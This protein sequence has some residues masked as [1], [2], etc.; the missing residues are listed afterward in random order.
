MRRIS[1]RGGQPRSSKRGRVSPLKTASAVSADQLAALSIAAREASAFAYCPYS[2]FRVGA[3]VLTSD[4]EIVG[5]CNVENA[6][7]GLSIC[8]ERNAIFQAVARGYPQI[9]ALVLYTPTAKPVTPCGACRQVLAEFG[10]EAAGVCICDGGESIT[11]TLQEL[12]AMPLGAVEVS[13]QD[14][15]PCPRA[16]P[17]QPHPPP[18][19]P[20]LPTQDTP[21]RLSLP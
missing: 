1:R 16:G 19:L 18:P 7:Y 13:F 21:P 5:A 3:A 6:S 4:G 17:V 11:T 12:L 8:A 20:P 2:N 10:G 14:K 9:R 15:D